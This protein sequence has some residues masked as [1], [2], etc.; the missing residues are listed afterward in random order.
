MMEEFMF[1][2]L[3]AGP[4]SVLAQAP[5][6]IAANAEGKAEEAAREILQACGVV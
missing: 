3:M 5:V 6:K 2:Q 4:C 1:S